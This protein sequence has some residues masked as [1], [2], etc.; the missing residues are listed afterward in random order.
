MVC[1]ETSLT[2][3]AVRFISWALS[4]EALRHH[5]LLGNL[6]SIKRKKNNIT[7]SRLTCFYIKAGEV[8]L[9]HV[10]LYTDDGKHN[11]GKEEQQSN[12]KKGN[13]GLHYGL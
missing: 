2:A 8:E 10:E 9:A 13:H 1:F 7:G 11:D 12:L 5:I 3:L 4:K 6:I